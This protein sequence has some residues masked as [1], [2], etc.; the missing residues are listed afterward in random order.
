[1]STDEIARLT[2]ERD[3]LIDATIIQEAIR[4]TPAT[5]WVVQS[6]RFNGQ[7]RTK[8]EAAAWLRKQVGLGGE[9]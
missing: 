1:M 3:A 4:G 8:G 5:R 9:R 6:A 7:F 2:A